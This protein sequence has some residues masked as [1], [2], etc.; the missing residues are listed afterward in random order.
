MAWRNIAL[1]PVKTPAIYIFLCSLSSLPVSLF[2]PPLSQSVIVLDLN[3]TMG[4]AH[5]FSSDEC[6]G[7]E[8]CDDGS[9]EDGCGKQII[10]QIL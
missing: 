1:S 8:D 3:V 2:A 9:D 4:P 6:D 5:F 10:H 7:H